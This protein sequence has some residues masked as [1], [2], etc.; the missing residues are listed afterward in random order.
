M[1]KNNLFF[2]LSLSLFAFFVNMPLKAQELLQEQS[3]ESQ[4]EI[5]VANNFFYNLQKYTG[6]NFLFDFLTEKTMKTV[7]KLKTKASDI[8]IDLQIYSAW[9][10]LRKK[11]KSLAVKANELYV[12]DIPVESFEL[13]T[14]DP[15]YFKKKKVVF[16]LRIDTKVRVDL[17]RISEILNSLPKWKKV[18][19]EL[20]L[21]I[22]PFGSTKVTVTNVEI[23][24]NEN[25]SIQ[26]SLMLQSLVNPNS[27]PLEVQFTGNLVLR[28]KKIIVDNLQSEVE[29]IFTKDSDIG[30]SFSKFLEDLINPIFNFHKY[31]KNGLTIYNVN[32]TFESSN[33]VL[34]IN[35]R[36]VPKRND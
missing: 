3:I 26:S 18:F 4:L 10:L 31:E 7:I 21:P 2:C 11:A 33:L 34:D 14:K 28:E 36:L 15:I 6:L 23:K 32:L 8:S 29:G 13:L 1:R 22:P 16:P 19:G 25:G 27:E 17:N 5:P 12:K 9:D 20:E 35:S 30:M 24:I